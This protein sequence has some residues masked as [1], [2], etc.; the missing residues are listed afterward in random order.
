MLK[1]MLVVLCVLAIALG[2]FSSSA[3]AGPPW[4]AEVV[5]IREGDFCYFPWLNDNFELVNPT[6]PGMWVAQYHNGQVQWNCH[7]VLDFDSPDIASFDDMCWFVEE[8]Y[9]LDLCNGNGS[10]YWSN[11]YEP[12]P[13]TCSWADA[14]GNLYWAESNHMVATP[15]G[16]VN[17]SCH[18]DMT[19]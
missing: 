3:L 19:P 14:E 8:V 7:T 18:F 2:L 9:G 17:I 12:Y 10:F 1:R 13:L 16:N 11:T 4:P 6:G 15:N 5:Q